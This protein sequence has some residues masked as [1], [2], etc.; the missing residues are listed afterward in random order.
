MY[1]YL[2]S[3]TPDYNAWLD[4]R[5]SADTGVFKVFTECGLFNQVV[6]EGDATYEDVVTLD[7]TPIFYIEI[8]WDALSD[9]TAATIWDW[10]FDSTKA[11]GKIRSFKW[12]HP[13]DGH[14]YV[15]RFDMDMEREI[16]TLTDIHS[17]PDIKLKVLGHT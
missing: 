15:V 13:T 11:F 7:S 17:M 4:M 1:D 3:A 8:G 9:T 10:Y 16:H 5:T 2:S 12:Y 6:H 14:G